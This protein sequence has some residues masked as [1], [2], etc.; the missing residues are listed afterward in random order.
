MD[1]TSACNMRCTGCWAAEY[2]HALNLSYEDICSIIDQGRELGCH[3]YIYTG[4]EPLVRK[5]DLIRV[6]ERYPDCDFMT[7]D[8]P[9]AVKCEKCGST[10]FRKGSKLYCAKEGC[11]FEMPVPKKD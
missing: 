4:G 9:V 6:C 10:L 11:G 2:G 3:V 8:M 5:A 7:W 1:P